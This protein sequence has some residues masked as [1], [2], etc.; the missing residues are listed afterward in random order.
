MC[1]HCERIHEHPEDR[2]IV[3]AFM[4]RTAQRIR[5]QTGH[6]RLTANDIDVTVKAN[7][8]EYGSIGDATVPDGKG[9]YMSA[10]NKVM[11]M[12]DEMHK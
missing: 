7:L 6:T 2:E 5:E 4:E 9:G 11:R 12:L 1:R 10:R 8:F 3:H